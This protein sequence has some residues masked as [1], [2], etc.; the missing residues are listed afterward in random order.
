MVAF[1]LLPRVQDVKNLSQRVAEDNVVRV[2]LVLTLEFIP[3]VLAI[4][5]KLYDDID[6]M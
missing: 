6:T 4:L 1:V 5:L 3:S 2:F